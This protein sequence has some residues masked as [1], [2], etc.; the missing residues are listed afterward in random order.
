MPRLVQSQHHR[1]QGSRVAFEAHGPQMHRARPWNIG[2]ELEKGLATGSVLVVD[3]QRGSGDAE[4]GAFNGHEALEHRQA[5]GPR[6]SGKVPDPIGQKGVAANGRDEGLALSGGDLLEGNEGR[7]TGGLDRKGFGSLGLHG[8]IGEEAGRVQGFRRPGKGRHRPRDESGDQ[9]GDRTA[10]DLSGDVHRDFP[11]SPVELGEPRNVTRQGPTV[12][13]RYNGITT[14]RSQLRITPKDRPRMNLF[15]NRASPVQI[16]DQLV[17]QVGQLIASGGLSPGQKLPSIRGLATRLGV[18]HLTILAAYRTLADR[19]VL[20]IRPGSG[21]RVAN[22][23]LPQGGWRGD[24]ALSAAAAYFVASARARGHTTEAIEQAF[25]KALEGRRVERLVVVN[26]HPDLQTLYGHELR[27]WIDLPITGES[28]EEIQARDPRELDDAC[29][30]T[31]TN[32]AG[33]LA[34]AMGPLAKLTVLRLNGVDTL[35]SA[36]NALPGES[37]VAV[38]S[39]SERFV[40]LLRQLL[41]AFVADEQLVGVDLTRGDRAQGALRTAGLVITDLCS[42]S[43]LKLP[44]KG[45]MMIHPL[46][47]LETLKGLAVH[48][49]AEVFRQGRAGPP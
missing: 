11:C 16:H 32:F 31:S 19:G 12:R 5:L 4:G 13:T 47:S 43:D 7:H 28:P 1:R 9:S 20:E 15:L 22:L 14:V 37:L 29:L 18:H 10:E 45:R 35:V 48:L 44:S 24:V 49:P 17:A 30:V 46:I 42:A 26:P 39:S 38:A 40:F 36:L 33:P 6:E 23:A 34:R 2:V 21:V 27:Q 8:R 25:H 41:A 3:H